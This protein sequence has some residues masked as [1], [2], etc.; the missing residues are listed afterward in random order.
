MATVFLLLLFFANYIFIIH[1]QW[2]DRKTEV[3]DLRERPFF[4]SVFLFLLGGA[5]G[6][7]A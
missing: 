5:V 6:N 4:Y 1:E 3:G 2:S 7:A